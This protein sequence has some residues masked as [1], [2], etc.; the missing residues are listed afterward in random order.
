MPAVE[1]CPCPDD[2]TLAAYVDGAFAAEER[3]ALEA[4]ALRCEP[5]RAA[6]AGTARALVAAEG[7]AEA[8]PSEEALRRA[9]AAG[10]RGLR[11]PWRWAAAALLLTVGSGAW[12]LAHGAGAP[13]V[14]R[15]EEAPGSLVVSSVTGRIEARP[16]GAADWRPLAPAE[17]VLAGTALRSLDRDPANVVFEGT[18]SLAFRRDGQ[19]TLRPGGK[20]V[21]IEVAAGGLA[22]SPPEGMSLRVAVP[23]GM[24]SSAGAA[25]E[26]LVKGRGTLVVARAG[27]GVLCETAHGRLP[28][29]ADHHTILF[30][31]RPPLPARVFPFRHCGPRSGGRQCQPPGGP[32][33]EGLYKD[34]PT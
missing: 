14:E 6:L 5:C 20:A 1:D 26:V 25:L 23:Q 11:G 10:S 4:H 9:I 30:D 8:G 24:V 31:D 7:A 2:E 17:R 34:G 33:L 12:I 22:V 15:A 19:A 28:L 21:D 29:A 3:S 18:L 27:S 16:P 32:E 13:T